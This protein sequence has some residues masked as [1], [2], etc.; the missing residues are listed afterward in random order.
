[1][2]NSR[3]GF[4][5][6]DFDKFQS[7]GGGSAG[8][9]LLLVE[10][11]FQWNGRS[12]SFVSVH[13]RGERKVFINRLHSCFCPPPLPSPL[14]RAVTNVTLRLKECQHCVTETFTVPV[15]TPLLLL[16]LLLLDCSSADP[17]IS[18]KALLACVGLFQKR[19]IGIWVERTWSKTCQERNLPQFTWVISS[20]VTRWTGPRVF[21]VLSF[22]RLSLPPIPLGYY[23]ECDVISAK[24]LIADQAVTA[25]SGRRQGSRPRPVPMQRQET[26][27][28]VQ[29]GIQRPVPLS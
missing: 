29:S 2:G 24:H 4:L 16:L 18:L 19:T 23:M 13:R 11:F 7:G 17:L 6:G 10:K 5:S 8:W 27:S 26:C 9:N 25:G 28:T 14:P 20:S 12:G 3:L 22:A 15:T 1:M 21:R